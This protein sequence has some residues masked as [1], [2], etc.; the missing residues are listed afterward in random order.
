MPLR[1]IDGRA[2]SSRPRTDGG[3][4]LRKDDDRR[5]PVVLAQGSGSESKSQAFRRPSSTGQKNGR[6]RC[7]AEGRAPR[8][9]PLPVWGSD[10]GDGS[11]L[12]PDDRAIGLDSQQPDVV[13]RN[14]GGRS[15][16]PA[17]TCPPSAITRSVDDRRDSVPPY[18]RAHPDSGTV[19]SGPQAATA[20]RTAAEQ[21]IVRR[22]DM[23][24]PFGGGPNAA[25]HEQLRVKL[26]P[27][28]LAPIPGRRPL[29][30]PIH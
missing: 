2:G 18:V 20:H 13:V 27:N 12:L 16:V 10:Q 11:R 7:G 28:H 15:T 23:S 6:S 30:P 17:T 8:G 25:G 5:R 24:L 4:P 3:S 19:A 9:E 1:H 21:R 26:R 29:R 14:P 22:M